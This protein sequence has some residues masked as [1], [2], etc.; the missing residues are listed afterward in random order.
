MTEPLPVATPPA[1]GESA[2]PELEGVAVRVR[3]RLVAWFAD[4][5][6]GE[7]WAR[8]THFGQ[9]LMHPCSIP[10]RPSFTAEQIA[11]ARERGEEMYKQFMTNRIA[12]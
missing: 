1:A 6:D 7:E 4:A 3:G 12:D 10:D 8:E 5:A 11:H 2:P 9:W